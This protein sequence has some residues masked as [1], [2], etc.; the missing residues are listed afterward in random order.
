MIPKIDHLSQYHE[1]R[2]TNIWMKSDDK[3][4]WYIIEHLASIFAIIIIIIKVY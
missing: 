2:K 4:N 3:I 1:S